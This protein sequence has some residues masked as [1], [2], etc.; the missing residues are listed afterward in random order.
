MKV[1]LIGAD[2]FIGR[3]IAFQLRAEGGEVTAQARN[4][5]QLAAMGFAK[6]QADLGDAVTHDPAFWLPHLAGRHLIYAADL[7][8]RA[9]DGPSGGFC[10]VHHHAPAAMRA[11]LTPG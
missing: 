9:F 6:V 11:A 2:G 3:P 10:R 1:L 5:A 8:R 7:C 4:P